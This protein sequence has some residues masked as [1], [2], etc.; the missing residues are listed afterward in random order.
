ME[1][2][3]LHQQSPQLVRVSERS[4]PLGAQPLEVQKSAQSLEAARLRASL[5]RLWESLSVRMKDTPKGGYLPSGQL[6]QESH[7][8]G[9]LICC[10]I[11]YDDVIVKTAS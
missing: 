2:P 9:V 7:V 3:F 8:F 4:V 6:H 11:S 10:L 5:L 1:L